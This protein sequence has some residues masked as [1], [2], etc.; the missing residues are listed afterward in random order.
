MATSAC[1]PHFSPKFQIARL[2]LCIALV[3][4][5]ARA[6]TPAKSNS[7]SGG[8]MTTAQPTAAEAKHFI[9]QAETRLLDLWI[10]SGR[11]SWVAENFITED[12]ESIN[13]DADQAVKAATADLANR[14]KRFD[15][16]QLPPDVATFRHLQVYGYCIM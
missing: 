14:A 15:K 1:A 16:V 10:K 7:P 9:E 3:A 11:A 12:T 2:V 5:V 13:A 6:Q 8:K 4:S